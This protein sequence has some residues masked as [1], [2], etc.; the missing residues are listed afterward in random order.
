LGDPYPSSERRKQDMKRAHLVLA[1]LLLGLVAT[2]LF[3][4]GKV[5]GGKTLIF[6]FKNTTTIAPYEQIFAAFAEKTGNKVEVQALPAGEEFGQIMMTRFATKDYPDAFEM[7]PG[8]KQYIKFKAEET[9]YD[10]TNSAVIRRVL[11]ATREFQTLNGKVYG[12]PWGTNNNLG[13]Y[14][15]KEIFQKLGV[16]PP[17]NYADFLDICAKAKAAGYIPVYEAVKTGWPAQIYSLGA[18]TSSVDPAIGDA[19]VLKLEKNELRLNAIPAF[20]KVLEQQLALKTLGYYQSDVLAGT[21]EEQQ[22]LFGTGK[23]AM[24]FQLA[25]VLSLLEQKFGSAFVN[26]KV[27]YFPVPDEKSAGIA[28]LYAPG[29]ILVPKARENVKTTVD[30]VDFM[31]QKESLDIYYAANKG[32]PIY[33]NAE[34]VLYPAQEDTLSYVKAGK[35]KMNVQNRLSSS[36]TD[37]PKILQQMFISGNVDEALDTLDTNYRNTGKARLLPGF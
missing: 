20:K 10:W 23:V 32:I 25:N 31:T 15:N 18:W 1:V 7:D 35:A 14:Y 6:V 34:S 5:E 4:S 19:G 21:Y 30:L 37:Y 36:F 24:I 33:K 13:V 16:K 11:D 28:T 26:E 17:K 27:G 3:A 29:Q 2:G 8:T 22:E 12:V 9:L